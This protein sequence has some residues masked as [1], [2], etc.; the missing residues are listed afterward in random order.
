[1]GSLQKDAAGNIFFQRKKCSN[2][3]EPVSAEKVFHKN[4]EHT[5]LVGDRN[6]FR[7]YE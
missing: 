2:F 3:Y 5:V 6:Y 7:C 4:T 1:M